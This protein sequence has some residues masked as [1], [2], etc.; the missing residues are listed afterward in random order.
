MTRPIPYTVRVA[1]EKPNTSELSIAKRC[2][3]NPRTKA[4]AYYLIMHSRE[5]SE[6]QCDK[7][8]S[9]VVKAFL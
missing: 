9:A 5:M 6:A 7:M 3:V 8:L 4:K 2:R 1:P